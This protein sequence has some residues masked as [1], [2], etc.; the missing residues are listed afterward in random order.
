MDITG[1]SNHVLQFIILNLN[2]CDSKKSPRSYHIFKIIWKLKFFI[3]L[4]Y[5][6]FVLLLVF[7]IK[8]VTHNTL[9]TLHTILIGH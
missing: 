7:I 9:W 5:A 2:C 1:K 3:Y 8:N 4:F 6:I